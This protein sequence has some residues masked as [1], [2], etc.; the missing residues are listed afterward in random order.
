MF[1]GGTI[2]DIIKIN[3]DTNEK[4]RTSQYVPPHDKDWVSIFFAAHA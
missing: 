3:K 1:R 4:H 2:V